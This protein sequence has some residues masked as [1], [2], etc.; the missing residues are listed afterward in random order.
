MFDRKKY[1]DFAKKQLKGRWTTPVLVTLFCSIIT[2]LFATPDIINDLSEN[3]SAIMAASENAYSS[4]LIFESVFSPALVYIFRVLSIISLFI[5][6]VLTIAQFYL[7]LKMSKGPQPVKFSDFID[8]FSLWGRGILGGL[9]IYLWT[10]LWALL[11]IIPGIIK[12]YAY[13]QTLYLLA[14]YPELSVTKAMK[15]SI[16]ITKGKKGSLFIMDLSFIGWAILAALSLGIGYLWLVPY[17]NMT[18]TNAY[19]GMLKDAVTEGRIKE[20]DLRG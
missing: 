3:F 6:F 8:G 18:K 12:S 4:E 9:W 11:F 2:S 1:K 7:Y 14:E 19:H 17:I 20:E 13:S 5:V 15:V 10:F 16:E